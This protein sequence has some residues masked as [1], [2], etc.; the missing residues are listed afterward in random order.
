MLG[1]NLT[2]AQPYFNY[3]NVLT[4]FGQ[5][6][7]LQL[8]VPA[9]YVPRRADSM[10]F[11][12]V[13][14]VIFFTGVF[15]GCS[16]TLLV[17]RDSRTTVSFRSK[18]DGTS[19]EKLAPC[20]VRTARDNVGDLVHREV[21][22]Q[23]EESTDE[24]AKDDPVRMV[25][26]VCPFQPLPPPNRPDKRYRK[27]SHEASAREL[28]YIG[29]IAY[30]LVF[31]E[32][33]RTIVE[34]WG[35][36]TEGHLHCYATSSAD[37]HFQ[38][39]LELPVIGLKDF[40]REKKLFKMLQYMAENYLTEHDFFLVA[41]DQSAYISI[42][43]LKKVLQRINPLQPLYMGYSRL[44]TFN[45]KVVRYCLLELG[46]VLSRSALAKLVG[47]LAECLAGM[48]QSLLGLRSDEIL[49]GCL[50]EYVG[51]QCT[52]SDEVSPSGRLHSLRNAIS[53][54]LGWWSCFCGVHVSIFSAMFNILIQVHVLIIIIGAD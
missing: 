7:V 48:D 30:D 4:V 38:G 31:F 49:G 43:R 21:L 18:N 1:V 11:R 2:R 5:V 19:D 44:T 29:I 10:R 25:H 36:A 41:Q 34:T 6:F 32:R 39:E 54:G 16:L 45:G 3:G 27:L 22:E 40:V 46:V 20:A 23:V 26:R 15:L 47:S 37:R 33:C 50:A 24:D 14:T 12:T 53:L 13:H 52:W 28:L 51:V 35:H 8:A 42:D 9:V 17:Q